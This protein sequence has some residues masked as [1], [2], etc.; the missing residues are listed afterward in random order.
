MMTN[1]GA[2][3][4]S[5]AV[6]AAD[7]LFLGVVLDVERQAFLRKLDLMQDVHQE[8]TQRQRHQRRV[9]RDTESVRD[10]RRVALYREL[11][12]LQR[13]A[14]AADGADEAEGGRHPH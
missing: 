3:N 6:Q 8:D 1:Y 4:A 14:N 12:A 11:R 10:G 2:L 7:E 5:P 9:E 13:E